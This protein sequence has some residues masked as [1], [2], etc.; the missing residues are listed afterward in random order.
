MDNEQHFDND[1][2]ESTTDEED[3]KDM[4]QQSARDE[5]PSAQEYFAEMAAAVA[6]IAFSGEENDDDDDDDDDDEDQDEDQG[7]DYARRVSN[8]ESESK[9]RTQNSSSLLESVVRMSP[10]T[11]VESNVQAET[12]KPEKANPRRSVLKAERDFTE[13]TLYGL[14]QLLDNDTLRRRANALR[15]RLNTRTGSRDTSISR[16]QNAT[17]G[18]TSQ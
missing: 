3:E 10:V 13:Y 1:D 12:Q 7:E 15:N 5:D 9:S 18:G 8:S 4:H 11:P 6:T 2:S 14:N 17:P 16:V